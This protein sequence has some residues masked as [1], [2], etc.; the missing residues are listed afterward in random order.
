MFSKKKKTL[1]FTYEIHKQNFFSFFFFF[2]FGC[3]AH[4]PIRVLIERGQVHRGEVIW[5]VCIYV[6]NIL[7]D[8]S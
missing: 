6:L 8:G 1:Y 3:V 2:F 7:L 4:I 5:Y